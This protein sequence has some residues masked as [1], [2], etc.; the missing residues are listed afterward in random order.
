MQKLIENEESG[1]WRRTPR[2]RPLRRGGASCSCGWRCSEAAGAASKVD[3]EEQS[4][5]MQQRSTYWTC[6]ALQHHTVSIVAARAMMHCS[7]GHPVS[8]ADP[9]R[10]PLI[11]FFP[12]SPMPPLSS[13]PSSTPPS[14]RFAVAAVICMRGQTIRQRDM[15][16]SAAV[17]GGR[18]ERR[19][20]IQYQREENGLGAFPNAQ[21]HCGLACNSMLCKL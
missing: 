2:G 15:H 21:G 12:V 8:A 19:N 13:L 5:H 7:F 17:D 18:A 1:C 16:A 3:R 9:P 4:A 14:R 20:N 6:S 10:L 11:A